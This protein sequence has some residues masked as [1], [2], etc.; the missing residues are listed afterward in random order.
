MIERVPSVKTVVEFLKGSNRIKG[1]LLNPN[2]FKSEDDV[3]SFIEENFEYSKGEDIPEQDS[4]KWFW[5]D[6]HDFW[7]ESVC[8]HIP[9]ALKDL[10]KCQLRYFQDGVHLVQTHF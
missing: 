1:I 2:L 5:E 8:E 7:F 10:K 4:D 9:S 6:A 3:T